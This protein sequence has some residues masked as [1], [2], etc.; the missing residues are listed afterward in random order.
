MIT[1][2]TR[3]ILVVAVLQ[4]QATAHGADQKDLSRPPITEI[5]AFWVD[6]FHAGI[7]SIEE[8]TQLVA[9][10]KRAN[11]NTLFVQVRRRGD[12]LYAKSFEPPVEDPAYDGKFDGLAAIL[13]AAHREGLQVHAWINAMPIWRE[14]PAPK[15]PRHVLNRH[16]PFRSGE[17]IWLTANPQGEMKFP[18]G[19][20]LDPGHPAA[21]AYLTEV[22]LN[23]VRNYDVD[24]IHFDYIRYPETDA[25][26]PRGAPVG[27]NGTSLARFRR[28]TNRTDTPAPDDLTWT[29]WRRQ[30]VTQLVRTG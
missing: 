1:N 9:D 7:R 12:A 29:L 23:I 25:R 4:L 16:G 26:M 6:G 17:D 20:F 14:L 27:Y 5:R 28:I 19:Y 15:D 11:I 30:Q 8:V 2:L 21:A 13:E 22:Y 24:G 10:A 18:V 3:L